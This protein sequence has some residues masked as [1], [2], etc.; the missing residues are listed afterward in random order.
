MTA[1]VV[2]AIVTGWSSGAA[3]A[4]GS[5]TTKGSTASSTSAE[6]GST[7]SGASADTGSSA[8]GSQTE[9]VDRRCHAAEGD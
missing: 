4:D 6:T 1:G 9:N 5:G 7:P 3:W 2:A 8:S